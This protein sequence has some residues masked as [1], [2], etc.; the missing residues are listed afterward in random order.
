MRFATAIAALAMSTGAAAQTG[1]TISAKALFFG[2]DGNVMSVATTAPATTAAAKNPEPARPAAPTKVAAA[3]KRPT[4]LG[5][6]YFIRLKKEDGKTQDVLA[7]RVFNSG[8]RFQLGVKVNQPAYVY[9]YN[10]DEGGR[11]TKLYPQPGQS[12]FVDAMGVVFFPAQGSF[13]FDNNPGQE[14]LLVYM[15]PRKMEDLDGKLA[16]AKPDLVSE[17]T[18]V[19]TSGTSCS[20]GQV[21]T[22]Q[23][24]DKTVVADA[25]GSLASKGINY[26]ATEVGCS[27][28]TTLASKAIVFSDDPNPAA[29]GQVASYVVKHQSAPTDSLHLQ[30]KLQHR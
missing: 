9:I 19:A 23:A 27:V 12:N 26:A 20:R 28:S 4:H 8:E 14:Q 11:L 17:P 18:K 13:Q 5:A 1:D 21:M 6:S 25:G 22:A 16:Q 24:P 3:P 2:T 10:K 30:L 29:G 15:S 7:S